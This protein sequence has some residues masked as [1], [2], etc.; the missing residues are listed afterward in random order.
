VV[1]NHRAAEIAFF[2]TGES[3]ELKQK[4]EINIVD[5]IRRVLGDI[6]IN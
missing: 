2:C 5:C 3:S 4:I 6:A 1:V